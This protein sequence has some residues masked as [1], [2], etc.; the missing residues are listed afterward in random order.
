MKANGVQKDAQ[1]EKDRKISAIQ[2]VGRKL[3]FWD[4]GV[5]YPKHCKRVFRDVPLDGKRVLE[6]GCGKGLL[7]VWASINGAAEVT[8]LEPLEDGSG[9]FDSSR[10]YKE[11][12]EMAAAADL[13]GVDM[14]PLRIQDYDPRGKKFDVVLMIA[15]V[16][17]IDE[18]SCIRLL[19]DKKSQEVYVEVFSHIGSLMNE[20]GTI[21]LID[22]S[23]K[24][25]FSD[26]GMVNPMAK[27]IEWFKHRSPECWA[28]LLGR[29]GFEGAKIS[30]PS[31]RLL[32]HL[33]VSNR[34]RGIS[35][36]LD[37]AFRLEMTRS[38]GGSKKTAVRQRGKAK[39]A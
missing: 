11:F 23:D 13:S 25:F 24:N 17:H 38:A 34:P 37:S 30:W 28:E 22:C 31:G 7:C 3:K 5:D 36:F 4:R 26:M 14:L 12:K 2:A 8:G 6:I 21:I 19:E 35:Y 29:S 15:S 18:D 33:G 32:R 10:V 9:S 27:T 16:N 39:G 1:A 20:G